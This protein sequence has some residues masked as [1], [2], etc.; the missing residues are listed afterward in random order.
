M[1]NGRAILAWEQGWHL[2]AEQVL[3]QALGHLTPVAVLAAFFYATLHYVVTPA[4][5][6]WMY[7][8]HPDRYR[9]ARTALAAG[10]VTGLVGF[11]LIPTAPPRLL[12][13]AGFQDTLEDVHEWGWWGDDGSVPRGLGNIT[14]QFAAMPSLHVG[15]AL[16][17]GVLVACFA[18]R[19][20]VRRIGALYPVVTT[21]VVVA[22][23]NHYLVDTVGGAATMGVGAALALL[24]VRPPR[25]AG[26]PLPGCCRAGP[27]RSAACPGRCRTRWRHRTRTP[28]RRRTGPRTLPAPGTGAG[29][30]PRRRRAP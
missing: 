25:A 7:R 2:D 16:W 24:L 11:A 8:C 9:L 26:S 30:H 1:R 28:T 27:G 17:S 15:W 13:G 4:V 10:T 19:R 23:G 3:N 20:S 5:L 22:T 14:N 21:L 6:L 29:H 18:S 12:S